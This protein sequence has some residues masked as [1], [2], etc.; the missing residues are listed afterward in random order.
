MTKNSD[1]NSRIV[2]SYVDGDTLEVIG[3]KENLTRERVRQIIKQLGQTN[4]DEARAA[5][6]TRNKIQRSQ[7]VHKALM[8]LGSTP[9]EL[10]DAGLSREQAVEHI[11]VSLPSIEPDII[12]QALVASGAIFGRAQADPSISDNLV[13]A[14]LLYALGVANELPM[15]AN[16]ATWVDPETTREVRDYLVSFEMSAEYVSQV[17]GIIASARQSLAE[18]R[19]LT[20]TVDGYGD[21]RGEL[22]DTTGATTGRGSSA[23]PPTSLTISKRLGNGYWNDALKAIGAGTSDRGRERGPLTFSEIDY[24]VALRK[25]LEEST[26]KDVRPTF[27]GYSNWVKEQTD[28]GIRYPSGA[29]LRLWFGN[30]L[31]AI[32]SV[33]STAGEASKFVATDLD[34]ISERQVVFNEQLDEQLDNAQ[35]RASQGDEAAHTRVESISE[36]LE[37]SRSFQAFIEGQQRDREFALIQHQ[38][39]LDQQRTE[40]A[41]AEDDLKFQKETRKKEHQLADQRYADQKIQNKL[42]HR[43]TTLLAIA[44]LVVS[45]STV[46]V[47]IFTG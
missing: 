9:S 26:A 14:A 47:S 15:I 5:R 44:A 10:A 17:L 38:D 36:L 4:A 33:E 22:I 34:S 35:Q 11:S 1:R 6:A 30:W 37:V 7:D 21:I 2:A 27:S 39:R 43:T 46:I 28:Q 42:Q 16:A 29:A 19:S 8:D 3:Q 40:R 13:K 20:I 31:D 23:W 45:V 25:Y 12:D 32:R 24:D 41:L 18:K